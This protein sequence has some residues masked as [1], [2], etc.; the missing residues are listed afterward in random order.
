MLAKIEQYIKLNCVTLNWNLIEWIFNAKLSF[1]ASTDFFLDKMKLSC[2]VV[3]SSFF[4]F[5]NTIVQV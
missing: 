1:N 2:E 5:I 4:F 3:D